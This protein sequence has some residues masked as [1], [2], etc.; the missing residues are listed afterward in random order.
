MEEELPP[1]AFALFALVVI[2]QEGVAFRQRSS[3]EDQHRRA[4]QEQDKPWA[5]W[6][7]LGAVAIRCWWDGIGL[8]QTLK[9]DSYRWMI[10]GVKTSG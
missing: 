3:G 1:E 2:L 7:Q 6:R 5:C 8:V 10:L 4:G 9:R